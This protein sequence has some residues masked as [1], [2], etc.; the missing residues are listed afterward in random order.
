MFKIW[1][2]LEDCGTFGCSKRHSVMSAGYVVLFTGVLCEYRHKALTKL[3][4]ACYDSGAF[5]QSSES[6]FFCPTL[7]IRKATSNEV[8]FLFIYR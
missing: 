5:L 3:L 7:K 4:P 2:Y 6:A 1:A 8:A